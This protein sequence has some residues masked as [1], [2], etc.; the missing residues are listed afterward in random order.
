MNRE[1]TQDADTDSEVDGH[2]S[3]TTAAPEFPLPREGSS[4]YV[5]IE[6]NGDLTVQKEASSVSN[7]DLLNAVNAFA[8]EYRTSTRALLQEIEDPNLSNKKQAQTLQEVD[9]KIEKY[10]SARRNGPRIDD[11][12]EES[13]DW[14]EHHTKKAPQIDWC[15]THQEECRRPTYF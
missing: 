14:S 5:A 7:G 3:R 8:A 11:V 15:E 2:G 6:K 10:A 9:G 12:R 4:I 13:A 1:T